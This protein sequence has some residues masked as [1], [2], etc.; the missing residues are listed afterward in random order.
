VRLNVMREKAEKMSMEMAMMQIVA[1][2]ARR[3]SLI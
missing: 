3:F 2:L 1:R